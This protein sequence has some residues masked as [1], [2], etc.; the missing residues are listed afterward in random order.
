VTSA[1]ILTFISTRLAPHRIEEELIST[2]TSLCSD[3]RNNVFVVSGKE[4]SA[5]T[6]TLGN[7]PNL[8]LAAEHGMYYSWPHQAFGLG[9]G[10]RKW[11]I[12]NSG[13]QD[14][15][16]RPTALTIMEVYTSRT[17]GSYIEQTESKVL[18]QYKDA[19]PEFGALQ[20]KE[21]EDHLQSVLKSFHVEVLRG[22][23]GGDAGGYIEVRPVG[24][25]KGMLL[26]RVLE[27]LGN[28]TGAGAGGGAG[29]TGGAAQ[30]GGNFNNQQ[31][32]F[33]LIIGDDNCDEPMFEEMEEVN[34]ELQKTKAKKGNRLRSL[35][36]ST[37]PLVAGHIKYFTATVGKKVRRDKGAS[38]ASVGRAPL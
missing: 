13:G 24:V 36:R 10:G 4:R 21:L 7:V 38:E 3:P 28:G 33:A 17:H 9:E 31:V 26:R 15:S 12:M 18:W 11:E 5:I 27:G 22:G 35:T 32:D 34:K 30:Q 8:G 19:D 25:S 23:G 16:W 1:I 6:E 2:L 29:T 20:S 14:R 37:F